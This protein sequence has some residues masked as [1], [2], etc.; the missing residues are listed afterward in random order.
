[1]SAAGWARLL[2][3]LEARV[4][5][6][7]VLLV[8]GAEPAGVLEPFAP[9]AGLGMLPA[10]LAARAEVVLARTRALEA[11]L[12]DRLRERPRP[13]APRFGRPGPDARSERL[14]TGA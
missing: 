1:M 11:A 12:A 14:D 3:D 5:A 2:D 7:E 9:P 8:S 6:G 10:S 4:E 13:V